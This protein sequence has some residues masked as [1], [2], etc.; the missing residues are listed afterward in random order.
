MVFP[1]D[2]SSS[3]IPHYQDNYPT[4]IRLSLVQGFILAYFVFNSSQ[5]NMIWTRNSE[6]KSHIIRYIL[7]V[8]G[9]ILFTRYNKETQVGNCI[10]QAANSYSGLSVLVLQVFAR[11]QYDQEHLPSSKKDLDL[12]IIGPYLLPLVH[13]R[14]KNVDS[15]IIVSHYNEINDTYQ[16]L[17]Y[18]ICYWYT[19]TLHLSF[20]II[21][22]GGNQILTARLADQKTEEG[23][24]MSYFIT[25]Y[26]NRSK[27]IVC[28]PDVNMH[29]SLHAVFRSSL[30]KS[31][32]IPV[33]PLS[34]VMSQPFYG[35][36]SGGEATPN[37]S[38][39]TE[40]YYMQI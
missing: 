32:C 24:Y 22:L 28:C 1:K 37:T 18:F 15:E 27:F 34:L 40:L 25:I 26:S 4:N 35:V 21:L 7:Q 23:K 36:I 2:F 38:K 20:V 11:V 30:I 29:Y 39:W 8:S 16:H 33:A 12:Q 14:Q 13:Y 9:S 3:Y 17:Y 5:P 6:Q 19:N 10:P 31:A